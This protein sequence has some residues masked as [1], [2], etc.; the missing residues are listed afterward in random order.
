MIEETSYQ[1]P[2]GLPFDSTGSFDGDKR[3]YESIRFELYVKRANTYKESP[4]KSV[5]SKISMMKIKEIGKLDEFFGIEDLLTLGINNPFE[6]VR[7]VR[8]MSIGE[9]LF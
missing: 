4:L 7:I 2:Q 8:R 3:K 1:P 6:W 9:T 5:I